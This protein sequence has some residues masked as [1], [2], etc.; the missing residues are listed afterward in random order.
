MNNLKIIKPK[1]YISRG[2]FI[3]IW[4][5]KELLYFFAWRELKIRY[6]QTIVGAGWVIF[7]PLFA[8]IIFTVFFNK[9]AGITSDNRPYPIFVFIGIVF[10]QFFST[11]ITQISNC[12][13][14]NVE[15]ITKVYF[16]RLILPIAI[17]MVRMIDFFI[18][19]SF[20]IILMFYYGYISNILGLL[21]FP[22]LCF[23]VSL[24]TIGIGSILMTIN[25]KHRDIK[26]IMPYFI[27]M[28]LFV[29][30]VI[31]SA[32]LTGVYSKFLALNPLTGIIKA[33]RSAIIKDFSMNWLQLFLTGIACV[34][35]LALGLYYYKRKENEII[36]II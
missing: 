14:D 8:M 11:S 18:A 20:L 31:Y 33:A 27:Q 6:K 19:A 10:W 12:L 36:D 29:T 34:I 9:L 35:F 13:V 22:F 2:D 25:A 7:Q 5:Y 1:K 17:V 16:P 28:M 32:S 24:F 21:L 26:Q 15:I 3:E 23:F 4:R 30:P